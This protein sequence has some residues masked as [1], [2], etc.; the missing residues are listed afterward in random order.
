MNGD[1]EPSYPFPAIPISPS[2]SLSNG[3]R[4]TSYQSFNFCRSSGDQ[5]ELPN[6]FFNEGSSNYDN[7]SYRE[8]HRDPEKNCQMQSDEPP[9][10]GV[11]SRNGRLIVA[12]AVITVLIIGG[13]VA[14]STG[15]ISKQSLLSLTEW[16]ATLGPNAILLYGTLYFVLELLGVPAL[17]LTLGAGYLFG[18]VH[19]TI[20][21]SISSSLAAAAAFL[22]ARYGLRDA[23]TNLA[24]RLTK[25]RAIDRAI[26][27]EG[28]KFVF[29]LRLSPL[30]PFSISN[31]LYGLTSVDFVQFCAASWLGMLP[32]TIAY[33]SAGAAV[34]ALTELGSGKV[35]HRVSS[36]LVVL[37]FVGT[38]GVLWFAGRLA[39]RII[40]D[41]AHDE[42]DESTIQDGIKTEE[43]EV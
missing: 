43:A 36:A 9:V 42:L 29:L 30:L 24:G 7:I 8:S 16:F 14:A 20:A 15:V 11:G 35:S 19:G 37:G 39:S 12:A 26:G 22:V 27:R 10:P 17:P 3:S 23:V 2:S 25:F 33:V 40:A 28:F 21:V 31:Y 38:I 5:L 18:V 1:R 4:T 41:I 6:V 13:V 34:S 32:G